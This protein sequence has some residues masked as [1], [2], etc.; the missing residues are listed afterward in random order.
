MSPYTISFR[1]SKRGYLHP[2]V[3]QQTL[4]SLALP[5]EHSSCIPCATDDSLWLNPCWQVAVLPVGTG[6]FCS[7]F[8]RGS[9]A[10]PTAHVWDGF[11]TVALSGCHNWSVQQGAGAEP[12]LCMKTLCKHGEYTNLLYAVSDLLH[13]T[14]FYCLTG[15][16]MGLSKTPLDQILLQTEKRKCSA[17]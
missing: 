9:W 10:G 4:Q 12:P 13:I 5:V 2:F 15:L 17:R 1:L 11:I 7:G 8:C 16:S 14:A 6:D 3:T